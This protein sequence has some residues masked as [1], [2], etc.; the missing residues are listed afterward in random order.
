MSKNGLLDATTDL[1]KID[2]WWSRVPDCNIALRTGEIFDAVDIDSPAAIAEL[3]DIIG[4]PYFHDG[5]ISSTGKGWH[6]LFEKTSGRNAAGRVEGVDYRGLNG[7]IVVAPSQHPSG[8]RYQ[9]RRGTFD[10]LPPPAWWLSVLLTPPPDQ[11]PRTDNP[12]IDAYKSSNKIEDALLFR[13]RH[14]RPISRGF[15]T[16]CPFSWHNDSDPSFAIYTDTQT[17]FCF[18]CNEWGDVWN[19]DYYSATGKLREKR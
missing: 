16:N 14:L 13:G 4:E 9:W 18:G 15:L 3:N 5:P 1:D 8:H 7:Y 19:L 12:A 17:F 10:H 11:R 2:F 6:L